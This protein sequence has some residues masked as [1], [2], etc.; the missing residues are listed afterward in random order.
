[1]PS[2]V[3]RSSQQLSPQ[4]RPPNAASWSPKL[5]RLSRVVAFAAGLMAQRVPFIVVELSRDAD[6]FMM[7]L[8]AALAEKEPRL[9]SERTRVAP[10]V[11]RA[12]GAKLENPRT[13]GKQARSVV[14]EQ[15][16]RRTSMPAACCRC[17][18]LSKST[19]RKPSAQSFP[20]KPRGSAALK[21]GVTAARTRRSASRSRCCRSSSCQAL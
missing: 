16:P 17:F 4:P 10:A 6:P 15:S 2:T 1:M 9:I 7:H 20:E 21:P 14:H 8:Y 18:A 11:G 19:A 12:N 13:S 3:C 5:D